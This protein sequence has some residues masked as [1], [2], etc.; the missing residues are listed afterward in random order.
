MKH[1]VINEI[2]R[3]TS[4]GNVGIGTS[5]PGLQFK[6]AVEGKIGAR[7]IKVTTVTPGPIMCLPGITTS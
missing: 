7:E 3:I 2:V 4:D 6:L 5:T 1:G